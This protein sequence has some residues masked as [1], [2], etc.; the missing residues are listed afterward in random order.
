MRLSPV[1]A[2]LFAALWALFRLLPQA[3]AADSAEAILEKAIEA[4]GGRAIGGLIADLEVRAETTVY[5]NASMV[6]LNVV[7]K[8]KLDGKKRKFRSETE[9]IGED[10]S[11]RATDGARSWQ[12]KGSRHVELDPV[13]FPQDLEELERDRDLLETCARAFA[14]ENLKGEG[15]RFERLP[16]EKAK[17][18][19]GGP[20]T[21]R[22]RRVPPA[23]T[24]ESARRG[25]A[26]A[27][28]RPMVLS[29]ELGTWRLAGVEL[30]EAGD[31]SP[32]RSIQFAGRVKADRV[33]VAG[34]SAEPLFVPHEIHVVTRGKIESDTYLKQVSIN[35]GIDDAEFTPK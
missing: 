31:S 8:L 24:A 22:L 14:L 11:I 28:D 15:V 27:L 7:Q 9:I 18:G 5:K 3:P 30:E 13:D 19:D 6:T 26:S 29:I 12:K 25:A 32:R 35:S 23:P 21:A 1:L 34:K 2:A 17:D 4:Q 16:D 33:T 10:P 20:T